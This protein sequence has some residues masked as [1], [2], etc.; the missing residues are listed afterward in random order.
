MRFIILILVCLVSFL[1]CLILFRYIGLYLCDLFYEKCCRYP[2]ELISNQRQFE[3]DLNDFKQIN[4][5]YR[6]NI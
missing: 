2:G 5:I 1:D 6:I 3:R 4:K